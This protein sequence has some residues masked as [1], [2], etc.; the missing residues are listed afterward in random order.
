MLVEE[1]VCEP[2]LFVEENHS[3]K[4]HLLI[5]PIAAAAEGKLGKSVL[6]DEVVWTRVDRLCAV[7]R[8]VLMIECDKERG[9]NV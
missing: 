2:R 3:A 5:G 6:M 7:A 9:K 1:L 8:H 4:V